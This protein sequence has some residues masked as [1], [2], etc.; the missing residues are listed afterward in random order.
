M[1]K[2]DSISTLCVCVCVC[3]F[4]C[5]RVSVCIVYVMRMSVVCHKYFFRALTQLAGDA[6]A[7]HRMSR[8]CVCVC[9]CMCVCVCVCVYLFCHE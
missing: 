4:V 5:V 8:L 7:G 6:E 2:L 1:H 9:A 3:V